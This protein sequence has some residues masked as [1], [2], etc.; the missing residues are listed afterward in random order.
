VLDFGL[1]KALDPTPG[2]ADLSDSPT[3]TSPAMTRAGVILGTAAYMSPEQARGKAAEKASDMWAFGCVFFEML[4]GEQAFKGEDVTDTLATI[5]KSEPNWKRLPADTPVSVRSLLLQC[6]RKQP[7]QRLDS[8]RAMRIAL[9]EAIA[10]PEPESGA[11]VVPRGGVRRLRMLAYLAAAAVA[12]GLVTWTLRPSPPIT[13]PISRLL[14][15]LRPAE[16]F[17]GSANSPRPSRTA[18]VLSPNGQTVVFGGVL[19]T[20]TQ[21]FTRNLSETEAT[22][23]VGTEGARFPI[24][25]PDGQW[26]AFPTNTK[27]FK[28]PVSGGP[29]VVICDLPTTVPFAGVTLFGASWGS[30]DQIVFSVDGRGIWAVSGGGG[31]PVA[32]SKADPGKSEARHILPYVLPNGKAMLYTIIASPNDWENSSVVLQSL[33]TAERRTLLRGGADARYVSTGHLLYMKTGTLMAVPF[34]AELELRGHHAAVLDG[35]M[36][37]VNAPNSADETGAGQFAVSEQGTLVYLPGGVYPPFPSE[38]MW[39]DRQGVSTPIPIPSGAIMPR[40][41]PDGKRLAYAAPRQFRDED[42]WIYDFNRQTSTRLTF[43]GNNVFPVWAPDSKSLVFTTLTSGVLN[44]ARIPADGSGLPERVLTSQ[45]N[46]WPS[47]WS[48]T[49]NVVAFL[50]THEG[51]NQISMM[52]MDGGREAKLFLQSRFPLAYPEFSPDGRWLAYASAESGATEVYVQPYPG[53]GEK[54]RI[55]PNGG[56]AP[57]WPHGQRELLYVR[58]VNDPVKAPASAGAPIDQVMRV[59]IDTT[60]GFRAS[61]PHLLYEGPFTV[62]S[63]VGGYDV[64]LNNERFII[65]KRGMAEPPVVQMQV[66]LNWV[67]ELKHLAPTN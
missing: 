39:V 12:G 65:I 57:L 45:S 44:L 43:Q 62:T 46:Q 2:T 23:L 3:I 17:V 38:L 7:S 22:P 18:F 58:V 8:A 31:T 24:L 47:S 1:A 9:A 34:D 4:S 29:P 10:M 26:V 56:F 55:S 21:L 53:P 14:L 60:N 63:P 33:E 49:G 41:S 37:A 40:L 30:N 54:V 11:S 19:G 20:I 64:A 32:I 16:Q 52:S 15:D 48:P 28:V 50:E 67:E 27:L 51:I 61:A 5:V 6:L 42:L 66:V 25:S 59:A 13:R 35:V 36:Q